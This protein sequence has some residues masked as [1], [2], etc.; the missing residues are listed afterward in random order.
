META[1]RTKPWDV[2]LKEEREKIAAATA[3]MHLLSLA[4]PSKLK[5]VVRVRPTKPREDGSIIGCESRVGPWISVNDD[6]RDGGSRQ[7]FTSAVLGPGSTQRDVFQECAVPLLEA[8]LGGQPSCLIAYGQTGSGKTFSMLGAEGGRNPSKLDGIVPQLCAELF[9]RFA[10]QTRQGERE[11]QI[12]ASYVE[13]LSH[14]VYDLLAPDAVPSQGGAKGGPR[15]SSFAGGAQQRSELALRETSD[16]DFLVVGAATER[17]YSSAGLTSLIERATSRRATSSNDFHEHSSRSHAFLTLHLE[18]R[19]A[20]EGG[21]E[22][23]QTTRFH[24]CDLA[25]SETFDSRQG[26]AGINGGLLA[27]GKVLMALAGSDDNSRPTTATSRSGTG[28]GGNGGGD[29]PLRAAMVYQPPHVP[30][31]D[32]TLTKM[33]KHV[34]SGNCLNM[35]LACVNPIKGCASETH[36]TLRC[37]AHASACLRASGGTRA[38]RGG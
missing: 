24:L 17:I 16:G 19:T 8:V 34:L 26:D 38:M 27:L 36:N 35:M 31:R 6:S 18:R 20:D 9:R 12:H 13:I 10:A 11:Y 23:R 32:A 4:T 21:Q 5:V 33:L 3:R 14:R 22:R 37:A 28:S 2:G 30:Y 25:G 7:E 1:Q 29:E 15:R